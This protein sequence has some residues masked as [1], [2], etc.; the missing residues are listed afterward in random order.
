MNLDAI[1]GK[2][3]AL[4]KEYHFKKPSDGYERQFFTGD[5]PLPFS[6]IGLEWWITKRGLHIL[7]DLTR[8]ITASD[9]QLNGD[10]DSFAKTIERV[11]ETTIMDRALFDFDAVWRSEART[12]FD[13]IRLNERVFAQRFYPIIRNALLRSIAGWL[14]LVPLKRITAPSFALGHDGISLLAS[15]DTKT[16]AEISPRYPDAPLWDPRT[17]KTQRDP[18]S[19]R[20]EIAETWLLCEVAGTQR[21]ARRTAARKMRTFLSVLFSHAITTSRVFL[22]KSAAQAARYAVQ[23]PSKDSQ[24]GVGY[25]WSGAQ[26]LLPSIS[27]DLHVTPD[28][29]EEVR[30]WYAKR[31][32]AASELQKRATTAS[33]FIHYG[34]MTDDLQRFIHFFVA[35][36][37]LF[38]IRGDVENTIVA[39]VTRSFHDS[40]PSGWTDRARRLF[41]LRNELLHGGSSVIEDWPGLEPYERHFRTEPLAD[42][43]LAVLTALRRFF[44]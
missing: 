38:G 42:V 28:L 20:G 17:G 36:D 13:I 16:W 10:P 23:F 4:S 19:F 34:V 35:L 30:S 18:P 27:E 21:G 39:G 22:K 1:Y 31:D 24:V 7:D 37:A 26:P 44:D 15:A 6:G 25:V 14:V 40:D 29:L 43:A 33:H 3:L 9:P 2:I 32:A 12:I 11:F 5:G 8:M 41:D